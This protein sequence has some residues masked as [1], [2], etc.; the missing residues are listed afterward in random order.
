[1]LEN[2]RAE[3]AIQILD[4]LLELPR[5]PGIMETTAQGT[6]QVFDRALCSALLTNRAVLDPVTTFCV[7]QARDSPTTDLQW[8]GVTGAST[9]SKI[10]GPRKKFIRV[11][12]QRNWPEGR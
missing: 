2:S 10:W 9:L 4:T 8:M 3:T 5:T 1:M 11:A 7:I 6:S 12:V